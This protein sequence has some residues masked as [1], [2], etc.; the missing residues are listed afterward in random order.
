M[1]LDQN[2]L[3]SDGQA[4]TAAAG[5]DNT[6]DFGKSL[7]NPGVGN[8]DLY[9]FAV[10]TVDMTDGGSD[11]TLDVALESDSAEAF[12][13]DK[14][15]DLFTFPA[16]SKAGTLK[17]AKFDPNGDGEQLQYQRL[18]YTPANGNLTTGSVMAGVIIGAAA[19]AAFAKNYVS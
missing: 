12:T 6:I 13:P 9:L 1:I 17:Y 10:L 4:I 3:F 15:R 14:T 5:S 2:L 8:Q 19:W 16:A 11:S 18:K 7:Q